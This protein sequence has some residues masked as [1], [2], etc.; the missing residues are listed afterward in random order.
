MLK[1][2]KYNEQ[3]LIILLKQRDNNAYSYLY[4]HYCNALFTLIISIVP[5]KNVASDILQEVF[6]KIYRKID[7]YDSN[8]GRLYT[9][10]LQIARNEAIDTLRSSQYKSQQNQQP[11]DNVYINGSVVQNI[12]EIGIKQFV[13]MLK[14]EYR[15]LID[16]SYFKGFTQEEIA[17]MLNIPLGTIKTRLRAALNQL[18]QIISDN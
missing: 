6:I 5:D 1:E 18:K 16:L 17:Q 2:I 11:L 8:K 12:D 3:E 4:D 14:T 9:W 7:Y 13:N 15:E 10:M